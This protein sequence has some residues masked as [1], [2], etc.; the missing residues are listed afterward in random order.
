[1]P[2]FKHQ[3][4]F[5]P[6]LIIAVMAIIGVGAVA[7]FPSL[8]SAG[9][10]VSGV[11]DINGVI[12]AN[13]Q[14]TVMY[15]EAD[16]TSYISS[17]TYPATDNSTWMVNN[18]SSK[19]L[20]DFKAQLVVNGQPSV[21]S[22]VIQT[23][24]PATN[25]VL[26]LNIP[27]A[28]TGKTVSITGIIRVNGYIP[29]GATITIQGKKVEAKG[30]TTVTRG[31]PAQETQVGTFPS[32]EEGQSYNVKGTLWSSTGKQ[33]GESSVIT[34]TAP[35]A[36][37]LLIINSTAAAPTS[38]SSTG[39]EISGVI[40]LNGDVPT[41]STVV[42]YQR[43]SGTGEYQV[44]QDSLPAVNGTV[45]KWMGALP[46]KYYDIFATVKVAGDPNQT[47]DDLGTSNTLT[48]AAPATNQTLKID[49]GYQLSGPVG[50]VKMV[51]N[52]HNSDNTWSASLQFET[53]DGAETYWLQ[54]GT[55][56]GGN[57]LINQTQAAQ[58]SD[59]QKVNTTIKDSVV[60]YA[61]YAYKNVA[62]L[63]TSNFSP[64]S[65]VTNVKCP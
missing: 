45:W 18:L 36:H 42:V 23:S 29:Q 32:A 63:S 39:V 53:I 14:V 65:P 51:C 48:V 28:P 15:K 10:S 58:D 2:L 20:Y 34:V 9:K 24:A 17:N 35:A 16:S 46:G 22:T 4:G 25:E 41:G 44:A 30:Y 64:F 6:F 8:Q 12:P 38:E 5:V 55:N 60:Y 3:K 37:E 49:T 27:S 47:H 52:T 40:Q 57:D 50:D 19:T 26:T 13:S 7:L 54:L 61:R 56:N 31:V 43:P 21:E 62:D 33:I 59:Y 1:M 11:F